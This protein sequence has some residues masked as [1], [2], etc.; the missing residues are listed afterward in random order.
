M[1]CLHQPTRE[2]RETRAQTTCERQCPTRRPL[3]SG[4]RNTPTLAQT[5][6]DKTWKCRYKQAARGVR[7]LRARV[8][9]LVNVAHIAEGSELQAHIRE[10]LAILLRI[11]QPP[12]D[13]L[14]R[15]ASAH[16]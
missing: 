12:S 3:P 15:L 7:N 6:R 9:H 5:T 10:L 8:L 4:R 13:N 11:R 2:R 16:H 1:Q 14:Q